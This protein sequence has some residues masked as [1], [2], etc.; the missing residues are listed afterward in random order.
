[1]AVASNRKKVMTFMTAVLLIMT[2]TTTGFLIYEMVSCYY[3]KISYI[4]G[5]ICKHVVGW[6]PVP[7]V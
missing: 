5:V 3:T 4:I 1:M 7:F 2:K 6:L